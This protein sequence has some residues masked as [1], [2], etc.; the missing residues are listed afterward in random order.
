ME[1]CERCG[2]D[3]T[4]YIESR[5]YFFYK[6]TMEPVCE[7][8]AHIYKCNECGCEFIRYEKSYNNE[9]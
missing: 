8:K 7:R 5:P 3:N 4:I 1:K 6:G 2:S 9:E